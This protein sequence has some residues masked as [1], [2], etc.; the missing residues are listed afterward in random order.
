MDFKKKLKI[1]LFTAITYIVLGAA[2]IITSLVIKTENEFISSFGFALILIG[3]VRIRNHMLITKNDETVKKQ[4]IAETDE[5]N[6][7]IANKA[8][9]FTFSLYIIISCLAV[10]V[11]QFF[12]APLLSQYI[13]LSVCLLLIIYWVSYFIIR[14]KS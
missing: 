4:E 11:L 8:K 14:K 7:Y 10:I 5:R 1:R 6:I 13:S 9:T 3:I 2:M 12:D